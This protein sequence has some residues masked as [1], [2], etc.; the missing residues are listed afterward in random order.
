MPLEADEAWNALWPGQVG[1]LDLLEIATEN[2]KRLAVNM[3]TGGNTGAYMDALTD[4]IKQRWGAFCYLRGVVDV[5]R[6]LTTFEGRIHVDG[7]LIEGTEWLNLFVA[8]GRYSGGGLLVSSQASLDN[9]Q[10]HAVLINEGQPTEIASL[11]GQYLVGSFEEH[12]LVTS[13]AGSELRLESSQL[14][15]CTADGETFEA[16]ELVIRVLSSA[17]QVVHPNEPLA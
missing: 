11:A 15:P 14:W 9:G 16:R 3:V 7:Q 17:L 5:V 8:N 12:S 2:E 4:D 6:N 13:Q 10:F 1:T